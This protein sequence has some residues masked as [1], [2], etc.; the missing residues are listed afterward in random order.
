M[1]GPGLENALAQISSE[2][3]DEAAYKLATAARGRKLAGQT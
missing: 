2:V 1:T 3:T